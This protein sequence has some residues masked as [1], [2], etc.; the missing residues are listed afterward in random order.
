M[1]LYAILIGDV[2]VSTQ[3]KE[4]TISIQTNRIL[5]VGVMAVTSRGCRRPGGF[6]AQ[7]R[8]PLARGRNGS[9]RHP[10][11]RGGPVT[12]AGW[13]VMLTSLGLVWGLAGWCFYRVLNQNEP[14]ETIEH[15]EPR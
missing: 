6:P 2:R 12:L 5:T 1:I 3:P 14:D 7:G 10:G 15:P 8:A 11:P 13:V 9:L 4:L